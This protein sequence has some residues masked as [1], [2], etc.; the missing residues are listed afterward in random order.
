M[1][2]IIGK[3]W[4]RVISRV[5]YLGFP[6]QQVNLD[7]INQSL[8][9][10]FRAMGGDGA[11]KITETN[12]L[13][14][15]AKQSLLQKIA[16]S[17]T[18]IELAWRDDDT[19]RLP[20]AIDALPSKE[21]NRQLYFWLAALASID[22]S[23]FEHLNWVENAQA[24]TL[25]VLKQYPG[26]ANRYQQLVN[27]VIIQRPHL[28]R[29][30]ERDAAAEQAIRQALLNPGTIKRIPLTQT[31][32]MPVLLWLH[33]TPPIKLSATNNG[34][35]D[36][37]DEDGQSKSGKVKQGGKRKYQAEQQEE[38]DQE[39]SSLIT[40]RHETDL[41]T[42]AEMFK[43]ARSEDDDEDLE[44]AAEMA[45][46]LDHLTVTKSN[47]IKGS[48]IKFDLDL[49][50]TIDDDIILSDGKLFP[51]WHYKKGQLIP[52]HCRVI[53]MVSG[54]AQPA[55]LPPQLVLS[56]RRVRRQFQALQ[57]QR[58]WIRGLEDGSEIDL[59]AYINYQGE[60]ATGQQTSQPAL[61]KHMLPGHRDLATL[62]LADLSLSTE[63]SLD[64]NTQIIDVIRD[65][66]YLFSE[67]L[68]TTNDQFAMYGF[69]SKK[70]HM[71]RFTTIKGFDDKYDNRVRGHIQTIKPGLF[72]RMGG[73]I[74]QATEILSKR[75]N[76]QKLLLLLTDGKPNDLDQ[77]EGRYGIEDTKKSIIEAKQ[78]GLIPFCITID[79]DAKEY[80]PYL[81]GAKGYI[82]IKDAQ[83]L[84]NE[85]PLLYAQ[86]T[87]LY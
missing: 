10:F 18:H 1:E 21:L 66:L 11:L 56:A 33:P 47:K 55:P 54:S 45:D 77:Y 57:S 41:F 32:S 85:L 14:H 37:N 67:S 30:K 75:P 46:D 58:Q 63:A 16:G 38:S 36:D 28:N 84:P 62:V 69:S 24:K 35:D 53:P 48:R 87:G 52:D 5:A 29:L 12:A 51:E 9:V 3:M 17:G 15:G 2:E 82:Q 13:E 26:L 19:L 61:Y 8:A 6:E 74:R 34:N 80:L 39:K 76:A 64:E 20:S 42:L 60:R 71:V 72:T 22:N 23:P 79:R 78:A 43:L 73:A 83:Q 68:A 4:H 40:V 81:F 50:C 65:S 44:N 59:E 7:D 70:R 27:Q 31:P 49:P 86:L 25:A